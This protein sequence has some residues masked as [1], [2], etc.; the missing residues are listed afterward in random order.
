MPICENKPITTPVTTEEDHH[1]EAAKVKKSREQAYFNS[2]DFD[3]IEVL[4]SEDEDIDES[5]ETVAK[6]KKKLPENSHQTGAINNTY[7]KRLTSYFTLNSKFKKNVKKRPHEGSVHGEDKSNSSSSSSITADSSSNLYG[8]NPKE[9]EDKKAT[10]NFLLPRAMLKYQG[11]LAGNSMPTVANAN[12]SISKVHGSINPSTSGPKSRHLT[13]TPGGAGRVQYDKGDRERGVSSSHYSTDKSGSSGYYST[14]L[15]STSSVEEHIY[16]EPVIDIIESRIP[17]LNTLTRGLVK[18]EVARKEFS[19]TLN[20]DNLNADLR[21]LETSIENLDRHLKSYPKSSQDRNHLQDCHHGGYEKSRTQQ[22]PTIMEGIDGQ[23]IKKAPNSWSDEMDDSL[24]DIDLDSFLLDGDRKKQVTGGVE[25]L[26]G[27]D[28]PTFEDSKIL[29]DKDLEN[30]Y[31]CSKYVNSCPE[32]A[33]NVESV[34]GNEA[35]DKSLAFFLKKYEDQMH[36]QSTKEMLEEIRDKLRALAQ[37]A[38]GDDRV[39]PKELEKNIASLKRELEA[40]LRLM[41]RSNEMEIKHFCAGVLNNQKLVTMTKAF[42]RRKSIASE[43]DYELA[44]EPIRSRDGAIQYN[45]SLED[46]SVR[47][48][49]PNFRLKRKALS[50]VFPTTENDCY[51]G[52]SS[53]KNE[54]GSAPCSRNSACGSQL[55]RNLSFQRPRLEGA[56]KTEEDRDSMLEWHKNKPSI[57]ELYY[58]TNRINQTLV[59][60]RGQLVKNASSLMSYPSSRPESD[61]TLDLPRAEQLR[62]K[63]EKE[64]KFRQR[65]RI[66]TT[67]L[68]LVFFLLTV[69]VVSLV[70]TR[71][72]RMFGSM[73]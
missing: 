59:G 23:S 61:F 68:S 28:N 63:M 64:K 71:G 55:Q 36:F 14:N 38:G 67:F 57:W 4:P 70:L 16:S 50:E 49:D 65:C 26:K 45:D 24:V 44:Y 19:P 22:L 51:S 73:L 20:V 41:N 3:A 5:K 40:Y 30:N 13:K 6:S 42:E 62:L 15:C 35:E 21:V 12:A 25:P 10:N 2:Y 27:I 53:T 32:D 47:C 8:I 17:K 37:T 66:L 7:L 43:T 34:L 69:M 52:A 9:V 46:G 60:K 48:S 54:E 31:K 18:A 72:K 33:Y 56:Q 39:I 1:A 11:S 58:G 29:D